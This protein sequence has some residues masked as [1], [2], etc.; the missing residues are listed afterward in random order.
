MDFLTLSRGFERLIV[1][2]AAP[3]LIYIGYRLFVIGVTGQMQVTASMAKAAATF[4]NVAPG[5]FCFMLGVGLAIYVLASP[6]KITESPADKEG[7]PGGR[8]ISYYGGGQS[9]RQLSLLL[10]HGL[11]EL[12]LCERSGSRSEVELDR[13]S[14]EFLSKFKLAPTRQDLETVEALERGEGQNAH[15]RLATLRETFVR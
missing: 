5:T 7:R 4:T 8:E 1:V 2:T 11:S 10:R 15:D 9:G 3:L 14:K 12:V 6:L 13:C